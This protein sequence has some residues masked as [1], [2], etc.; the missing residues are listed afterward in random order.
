MSSNAVNRATRISCLPLIAAMLVLAA[1]TANGHAAL[2]SDPL[3]SDRVGEEP[4][5]VDCRSIGEL[6]EKEACFAGTKD[7]LIAQCEEMRLHACAPYRDMHRAESR[8]RELNARLVVSGR[9]RYAGYADSDPSYLDDLSAYIVASD[10]SWRAWRD[11]ACSLEPFIDGMSR[12]E[13]ADLTEACRAEW[14]ERRISELASQI[15]E[16]EEAKE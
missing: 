6:A 9:K 3:D 11:A 15:S 13:S 4:T 16:I 10:E 8:L 14:T 12:R 5:D 2:T 7:E 1:F